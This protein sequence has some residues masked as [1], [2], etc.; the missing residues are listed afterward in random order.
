MLEGVKLTRPLESEV[1]EIRL[2]DL[3]L[4]QLEQAV[5]AKVLDGELIARLGRVHSE[6]TAVERPG[7]P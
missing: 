7:E 5:H 2:G 1:A 3:A 4:D 6:L